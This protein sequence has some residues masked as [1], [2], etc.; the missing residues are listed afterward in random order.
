MLAVIVNFER[1]KRSDTR[2]LGSFASAKNILAR[3]L[4][5]YI[6]FFQIL[7]GESWSEMIA[8]PVIW[9]YSEDWILA[10]GAALYFVS[11]IIISGFILTN[12]VVAVLLDKMSEAAGDDEE[13][14][15]EDAGPV[16]DPP[17]TAREEAMYRKNV[18]LQNS[19][20]KLMAKVS[21][22]QSEFDVVRRDVAATK[23]QIATIAKLFEAHMKD[24]ERQKDNCNLRSL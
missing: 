9:F 18:K 21:K 4:E 6:R 2:Q 1:R 7:T 12:V 13:G 5:L 20:D 3:F 10:A 17:L 11:F 8:R 14:T 24:G 16:A 23:E 15:E 22:N 19:L